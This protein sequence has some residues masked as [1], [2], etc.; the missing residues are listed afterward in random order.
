MNHRLTSA[1][2]VRVLIWCMPRYVRPPAPPLIQ[3]VV[4]AGVDRASFKRHMLSE[5]DI[6]Y[7]E[8]HGMPNNIPWRILDVDQIPGFV[9]V[10][11]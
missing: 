11:G 4:K 9:D 10:V 1:A 8:L 7:L 5:E 2:S 3:S 6:A